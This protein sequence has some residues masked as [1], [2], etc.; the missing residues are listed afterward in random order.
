VKQGNQM[1]NIDSDNDEPD[2][3]LINND[4]IVKQIVK[5][6]V[7]LKQKNECGK[8]DL[9]KWG[10]EYRL[11]NADKL[12]LK[13]EERFKA[14]P[15]RMNV[16]KLLFNLNNCNTKSPRASTINFYN[17]KKNDEGKWYVEK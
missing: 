10:E 4:S 3:Q 1:I 17:L 7:E 13:R 15:K 5:P 9:K 11:K 14:D 8:F 2:E 16:Q 6:V 12:K